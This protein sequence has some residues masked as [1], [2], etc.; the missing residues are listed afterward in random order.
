MTERRKRALARIV[1]GFLVSLGGALAVAV[2]RSLG[3]EREQLTSRQRR[4]VVWIA[5][6]FLASFAGSVVL[7]TAYALG[8][9]PQLEGAMLFVSLGGISAGLIVW[10]HTLMPTAPHAQPREFTFDSPEEAHQRA[11]AAGAFHEGASKI[12]RRGFLGRL[13]TA[14]VGALG[15]AFLF[16]I[17]SCGI[18]PG[19]ALYVTAWRPGRRAVTPDG[20]PVRADSL[21]VNS[22]VTVF[23]EGATDAADSQLLL[24]KMD[25]AV[26]LSSPARADWTAQG[27]LG[28]SKIC[29]HAGC[30]VGLYQA[31]TQ[32]L[33]C[34][35]H[36]SVFDV[37]RGAIPT[38]G[39]ATR[40]LPQLPLGVDG[41]GFIIATSD[42]LEPV[43]PEFWAFG[44]KKR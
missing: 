8:G 15:L 44:A 42:F 39:P 33:F 12:G 3:K 23:P 10:A 7:G 28:F 25:P 40:A 37:P 32:Q 21:T 17:R 2:A 34:P 38:S 19:S 9:N 24:I 6:A 36:Q 16:P 26:T 1:I 13:L 27:I 22:V 18:A 20:E 35:C 43:G 41:D 31:A 29:T 4:S 30:P 5:F 14:A 11:V